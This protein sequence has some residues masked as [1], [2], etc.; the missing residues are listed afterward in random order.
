MAKDRNPY[1]IDGQ[2]FLELWLTVVKQN[3][4]Q[5]AGQMSDFILALQTQCDGDTQNTGH[6]KKIERSDVTSKMNYYRREYGIDIPIPEYPRNSSTSALAA[7][8]RE[9]IEKFRALGIG[10]YKPKAKSD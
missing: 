2:I 4:G 5:S 7:R 6:T 8:K 9:Y 1:T 10:D 3:N